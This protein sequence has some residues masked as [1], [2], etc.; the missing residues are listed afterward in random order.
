MPGV[1]LRAAGVLHAPMCHVFC[2]CRRCAPCRLTPGVGKVMA[3]LSLAP[4]MARAVLASLKFGATEE[5]LTVAAML[6]VQ[7]VWRGSRAARKAFDEA[8]A[9]CVGFDV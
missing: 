7:S 8:R 6:S 3:E 5:V 1:H 4:Q 2:T 9:K